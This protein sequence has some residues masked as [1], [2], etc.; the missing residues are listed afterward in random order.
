MRRVPFTLWLWKTLP[1]AAVAG[2]RIVRLD[3][4]AC[5]VR[6]PGGWR[7]RNPFRSTYFAAQTMAAEMSTAA[8]AMVLIRDVSSSVALIIVGLRS[9]Y[10]KKLVGA[11]LFSFED[12]SG[13][14][15]AIDRASA[16]DEPQ[17]YT[18]RP[19][20]RDAGGEVVSTFEVDWSFKRRGRG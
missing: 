13:M 4:E 1:L 5:A 16:S 14:K 11:G 2:L 17:R 9:T 19:L 15:A 8:P 6:L 3:P 12:I 10:T 18:A 7:T 20:G